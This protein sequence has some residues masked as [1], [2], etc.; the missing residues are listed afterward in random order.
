[1]K[2][3]ILSNSKGG[4]FTVTIQWAKGLVRKGCDVNIFFLTQSKETKRLVP[5]EHIRF[6]YF[7]VSNFLPNLR[8]L[9]T[10]LI[11]DHPDVIHINFA[12]FGPLAIFKKCVFK[13]PFIYTLHGLPQPWLEPSLLYKIAYTVEQCLLPFV[14]SR[15]SANVAVSNYVRD[16]LKKKRGINSE[17]IHNAITAVGAH[18][19]KSQN[20][21]LSKRKLGY[22][23]TDFLVLF[24]GKLHP[25]KDPL[26]L[27]RSISRV[28]EENPNLFLVIIGT[29]ELYKEAQKEVIEL[30]LSSHVK[31]L[32]HISD[33][34][35]KLSYD[36]ADIFVLP[37]VNDA[38]PMVLLEAMSLGIPVIAS[39]AGGCPE[40][41]GDA[42]LLF[43]QGDSA[44][45][46]KK[47]AILL[48]DKALLRTLG[49]RGQRRVRESFSLEDKV[50][51]YWKLY[52][53][54][55]KHRF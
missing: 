41:V 43:T 52:E 21:G 14:V 25:Y 51:Q 31:F 35:L 5:S 1:M 20:K 19:F 47:I 17:V 26:T 9:V 42:G 18:R 13:T 54:V 28:V 46:A 27:I 32:G 36:A 33:E 39:R 11:H 44:D 2:V 10:F 48:C 53:R 16:M 49:E 30:N 50:T 40:I 7:I 38:C 29:G 6:H 3:T 22:K 4:V 12:L 37:S 8:D 23:E 15:S 45:L 24:V 55:L 34:E